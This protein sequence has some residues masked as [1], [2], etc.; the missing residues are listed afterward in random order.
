M[1]APIQDMFQILPIDLTEVELEPEC[2]KP[3]IEEPEPKMLACEHCGWQTESER[4]IMRHVTSHFEVN[5][6]KLTQ[7]LGGCSYI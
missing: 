2:V 6:T 7:I 3:K 5:S 1:A 4:E